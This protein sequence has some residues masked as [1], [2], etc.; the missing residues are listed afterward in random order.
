ML[1]DHANDFNGSTSS[2]L[3][4]GENSPDTASGAARLKMMH[5]HY[6]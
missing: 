1:S 4:G 5:H 3:L 2:M 6:A